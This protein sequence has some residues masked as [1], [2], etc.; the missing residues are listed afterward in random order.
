MAIGINSRVALSATTN[1]TIATTPASGKA[2]IL[3]VSLANRT[4][5]AGTFNL[6]IVNNGT[7]SPSAGDYI[8]IST[9]IAAY[10]VFEKTGIVIQNGQTIVAYASIAGISAV[11]YG[12]EDNVANANT[13]AFKTSLSAAT[14]AQATAGPA[15]G[16]YQTVTIHLCNRN[17][18]LALIRVCISTTFNSPSA[19]DYIEYDSILPAGAE[20]ERTGIVIGNGQQIGVYSSVGTVDLVTMIVDDQ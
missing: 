8:E 5:T 12:L 13:G 11:T 1:T 9:P 2:Q 15:S 20:L 19:G 10:T 4:G 17:T 16:R 14:W 6:A 3:T 7:T 18:A